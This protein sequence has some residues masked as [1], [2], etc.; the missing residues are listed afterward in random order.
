MQLRELKIEISEEL[1]ES[2]KKASE[3]QHTT[4]EKLAGEL[5][6]KALKPA[7]SE[8]KPTLPG[9]ALVKNNFKP[10]PLPSGSAASPFTQQKSQSRLSTPQ[11][12]QMPPE[13]LQRH[14]DLEA[15]MKEV[16]LLI[17]TAENEEKREEYV[18]A[19]AQLAAELDALL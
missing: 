4:E 2:L 10:E 8:N 17:E 1:L 18:Q 3:D 9:V 14:R 16:S 15:R 12:A 19:Y 5:L 6:E 11:K 13:K 7:K